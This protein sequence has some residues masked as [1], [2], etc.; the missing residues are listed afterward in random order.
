MKSQ[1]CQLKINMYLHV[2]VILKLENG[3][4]NYVNLLFDR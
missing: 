4:T 2:L 3:K 1:K